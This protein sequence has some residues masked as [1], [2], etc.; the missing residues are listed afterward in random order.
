MFFSKS[1]N[2]SIIY[3]SEIQKELT[4]LQVEAAATLSQRV[5]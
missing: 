2:K 1:L 5:F 3:S 4:F